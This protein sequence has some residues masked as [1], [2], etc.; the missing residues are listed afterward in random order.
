MFHQD[1]LVRNYL[2]QASQRYADLRDIHHRQSDELE[3]LMSPGARMSERMGEPQR[4]STTR[5]MQE[6]PKCLPTFE[7]KNTLLLTGKSKFYTMSYEV[8][9]RTPSPVGDRPSTTVGR[10]HTIA[11]TDL[12]VRRLEDMYELIP[13][14]RTGGNL[15]ES[16]SAGG[17]T[18]LPG[19]TSSCHVVQPYAGCSDKWPSS[20][21][22]HNSIFWPFHQTHCV[23][24]ENCPHPVL[25]HTGNLCAA[26]YQAKRY[27][28]V[29]QYPTAKT[30]L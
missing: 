23:G 11:T 28:T 2:E 5:T 16:K 8:H 9:C 13:S 10:Y 7:R 3:Q 4:P 27:S 24:A 25:P 20:D 1:E 26:C 6:V 14:V 15:R 19:K 21:T 22:N 30:K 29:V 17:I 12:P 18:T